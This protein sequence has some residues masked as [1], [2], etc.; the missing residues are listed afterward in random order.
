MAVCDD[1]VPLVLG[2]A[3][4]TLDEA[5]RARLDAHVARCAGCRDALAGQVF[6]RAALGELAFA[7]VSPGFAARVRQRVEPRSWWLT[8]VNWRAWTLRLAPVAAL[9][10]LLA[11]WPRGDETTT[12]MPLTSVVHSWAAGAESHSTLL[13]DPDADSSALVSAALGESSR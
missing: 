11:W 6:V 3:E 5:A 7:P 13:F 12:R 9:L 1:M 10:C 2:A 8:I 4:G